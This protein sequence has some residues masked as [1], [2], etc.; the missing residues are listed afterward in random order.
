MMA[1][2]SSPSLLRISVFLLLFFVLT[3]SFFTS[4]VL[5]KSKTKTSLECKI[6]DLIVEEVDSLIDGNATLE[7][8]QK[9]LYEACESVF[10]LGNLTKECEGIVKEYADFIFYMFEEE[11]SPDLICDQLK[12]CQVNK[13]LP[14]HVHLA[15]VGD[16]TQMSV[17]WQTFDYTNTSIVIYGLSE[18]GPWYGK[19]SGNEYTYL[20]SAGY[21]HKVVLQGLTPDTLYFYYCGDSEGGW[22][23]VFSFKTEA[24][25]L[26]PFSIAVYGDMGVHNNQDTIPRIEDLV[27]NHAIDWVYHVGDFGYADDYFAKI[28]EYVLDQWFQ[29]MEPVTSNLP[30]MTCPG[31]HE[32]S[33]GHE[34]CDYYSVNFTAYNYRFRMPGNESGTGTNMFYSFDYSYAHFISISSE[35]DYPNSPFNP[36]FGDI[37][38]L[39]WLETDLKNAVANRDIR[40]WI[41]GSRE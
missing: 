23:Q 36:T 15:L 12:P 11:V 13:T 40:P 32:Y 1:P 30:Y 33:C 39:V 4:S 41:I 18:I 25:Q 19:A 26:T 24:N 9:L 29:E 6:C 8:V 5:G 34:E 31:N 38:Q 3:F 35:T 28:Y 7:E 17:T 22:S 27:T 10:G 16:P 14:M 2:L 21:H 20:E 37:D